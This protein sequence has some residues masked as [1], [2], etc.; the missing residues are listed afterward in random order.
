[1]QLKAYSSIRDIGPEA[2]RALE[3]KTYPFHDYSFH[4]A[5]EM[6]GSIGGES[7]WQPLYLTLHDEKGLAG[8]HVVYVKKHSYGE[9]IFDWDWARFYAQQGVPYYPKLVSALPFTPAT[10]PRLLTR[11]GEPAATLGPALVQ[12]A[13]DVAAKMR[14]SSFHALFLDPSEVGIFTGSGVVERHSLQY[15]WHNQGYST[16][17]N[18]LEGFVGKRR[19]D[20][21]RERRR[22]QGH[23]LVIERLSGSQLR[24][25]HGEAM[26][27][28]YL[29][30]AEKKEA[31]PYLQAG[32]FRRVFETMADRILFVTARAGDRIIAGSLNFM[33]GDHLYGRYWGALASY[34]DLHFEL[35]YYQT[36][37]FAIE[38]KLSLFEAGA[39]GEHK[40]QRG[41]LPQVIRSAHRIFD[42]RLRPAIE[43]YIGEEQR[44]MAQ[45]MEEL[46][47]QN[48]FKS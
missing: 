37:D 26:E 3:C 1:M 31:I 32:F 18:Y 46:G 13:L 24:A 21:V 8:A 43:H 11:A 48:P 34:P 30:T 22:A 10:G 36:L 23:G 44:V 9:Y 45:A 17:D 15:H 5:L 16:F 42:P 47:R 38:H 4:E 27:E 39:Q 35:C 20:I 41:F 2:W 7:G 33:K 19:R 40:I 12:A 6:T 25:E 29:S 28:L 14:M